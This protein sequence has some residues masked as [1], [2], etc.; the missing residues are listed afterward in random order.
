MS[1][2]RH[3]ASTLCVAVAVCRVRHLLVSSAQQAHEQPSEDAAIAATSDGLRL[4][5][6]H[7]SKDAQEVGRATTGTARCCNNPI[8]LHE[9]SCA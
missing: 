2:S 1:H 6:V 9:Q 5:L 8:H 7:E 4:A 3:A